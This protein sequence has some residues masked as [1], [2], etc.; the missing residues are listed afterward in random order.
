MNWIK[1]GLIYNVEGNLEWSLSHAQVP[2]A[3]ELKNTDSIRIFFATRDSESCSSTTFID[4]EKSNPKNI[5]Y[6]HDQPILAKGKKG[7]FDDAGTMPSW[8]VENEGR[9][10]L[11]YTAWN[12]SST[13]SYRLSIGIA[14][15]DDEGMTFKKMFPGPIMDR[16]KNDPVWV[17]QPC[18]MIENGLWKM[19]Y[20]SCQKSEV[21][22]GIAEPFYTVKYAESNNGI[23]WTRTDITCIGLDDNTDAI[24]RPCVW[25]EGNLFKM[26]H[27]NRKALDYRVD[28]DRSYRITYSESVDGIHWEN[29]NEKLQFEKSDSGW[30]SIMNEYCS[31]FENKDGL[32]ML[33]NGNGFGESGIGW[34]TINV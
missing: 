8:F 13:V 25:K 22:N 18:V 11:Y 7:D 30:D 2:F 20:L 1:K 5:R 6:I 21:I 12:K 19:W 10:Y 24:G 14:V 34:A 26:L 9:L 17:G 28:K 4:V 31:V 32:Q 16:G 15:S 23:D 3:Y 27:S 29:K 33:Y